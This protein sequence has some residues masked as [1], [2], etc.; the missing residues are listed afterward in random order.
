MTTMRSFLTTP[1]SSRMPS[2]AAQSDG[3]REQML[4]HGAL[5]NASHV[6]LRWS[7]SHCPTS[8]RALAGLPSLAAF[9]SMRA[10]SPVGLDQRRALP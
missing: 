4:P 9:F 10:V 8:A 1:A 5:R 7:E 6:R 2:S 3:K